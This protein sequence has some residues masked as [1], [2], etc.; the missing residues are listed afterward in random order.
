MIFTATSA[1]VI[2]ERK[3]RSKCSC[4]YDKST[5]MILAV[6]SG[7]ISTL[8]DRCDCICW[9]GFACRKASNMFNRTLGFWEGKHVSDAC[10]FVMISTP[11]PDGIFWKASQV[12]KKKVFRERRRNAFNAVFWPFISGTAQDLKGSVQVNIQGRVFISGAAPFF[13]QV[14]SG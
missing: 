2:G 4:A 9:L 5:W 7:L 11:E 12:K 1:G 14:L 13:F 8:G 6:V 3:Q 10:S